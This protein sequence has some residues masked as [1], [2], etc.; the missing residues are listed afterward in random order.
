M[1]LTLS[2]RPKKPNDPLHV[3]L[4]REKFGR[5]VR[6]LFYPEGQR[7]QPGAFPKKTARQWVNVVLYRAKR[8]YLRYTEVLVI[9]QEVE[10]GDALA[11]LAEERGLHLTKKGKIP[12]DLSWKRDKDDGEV[13]D[14][15]ARF[16]CWK[17]IE[18]F[19]WKEE[20]K[21]FTDEQFRVGQIVS[22][23]KQAL[24]DGQCPICLCR[25]DEKECPDH[26]YGRPRIDGKG[27]IEVD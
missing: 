6:A 27:G 25:V 8:G 26:G 16:F 2:G 14:E 9:C 1:N 13:L 5:S 21:P 15:A 11:G 19:C 18:E 20:R 24:L 3:I 12:H 10:R 7:P 22:W 23:Q 4:K 17:A